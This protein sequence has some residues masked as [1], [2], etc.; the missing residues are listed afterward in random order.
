M[1]NENEKNLKNTAPISAHPDPKVPNTANGNTA[2]AQTPPVSAHPD[3]VVPHASEAMAKEHPQADH[4]KQGMPNPP[5]KPEAN[6]EQV[7][8]DVTYDDKVIQKIISSALGK[9]DGLLSMDGGFF[10]NVAGKFSNN[11]DS[12][13]GIQAEV[14]GHHVNVDLNI[15]VEYGKDI[16]EVAEQ[17]KKHI[18]EEVKNTTHLEVHEVNVNVT[19]IKSKEQHEKDSETV[20]DKLKK[21]T[22]K[23]KESINNN[24]DDTQPAPQN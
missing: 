9:V 11:D 4:P 18:Y 2:S 15:V 5:K 23:A 1:N 13:S 24:D 16:P 19:D 8:G 12:T 20:Q 7:G 3:P 21:A 6:G 17:I 10:S 14:E 22:E